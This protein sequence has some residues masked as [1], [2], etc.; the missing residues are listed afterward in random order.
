MSS[1][2]VKQTVSLKLDSDLFKQI[3]E[4][5]EDTGKTRTEIVTEAIQTMLQ[6]KEKKMK[7]AINTDNELADLLKSLLEV[8]GKDSENLHLPKEPDIIMMLSSPPSAAMLYS[9]LSN[10]KEDF[11]NFLKTGKII[12]IVPKDLKDVLEAFF[13]C[14]NNAVFYFDRGFL[15]EVS[16]T[17]TIASRYRKSCLIS[18]FLSKKGAIY[19]KGYE[20][21][22]DYFKIILGIFLYGFMKKDVHKRRIL[23]NDY[24]SIDVL[25]EL[26][27]KQKNEYGDV[28]P[29]YGTLI[30]N[31][32][33]FEEIIKNEEERLGKAIGARKK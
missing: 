29:K 24:D 30:D 3:N 26:T 10:S 17:T 32:T 18:N 9:L 23:A 5:C 21:G 19:M 16:K 2:Q 12:W 13:P 4:I 28:V 6:I 25:K 33:E 11:L 27:I 8:D 15:D 7:I 1:D 20:V 31:M 22:E 14:E